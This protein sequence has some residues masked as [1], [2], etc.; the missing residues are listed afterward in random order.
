MIWKPGN[1]EMTHELEDFRRFLK[2]P[3][4]EIQK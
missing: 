2:I 1:Q 4:F 3:A